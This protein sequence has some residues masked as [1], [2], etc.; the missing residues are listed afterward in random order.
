M[1]DTNE[2]AAG[3]HKGHEGLRL[4][5]FISGFSQTTKSFHGV[6]ALFRWAL[7]ARR[8]HGANGYR[9]ELRPWRDNWEAVA[10]YCQILKVEQVYLCAYS[11]G[12]GW[13]AMQLAKYLQRLGIEVGWLISCDGVYRW[14]VSKLARANPFNLRSIIHRGPLA[15]TIKIPSN[16]RNVYPL[17]QRGGKL[18]GHDFTCADPTLT[19]LHDTVWVDRPHGE[20]DDSEEFA[21]IVRRELLDLWT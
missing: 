10:R 7:F 17:R 11:W 9:I 13:G 16:V 1:S 5:L 19:T 4:V 8:A 21:E 6:F 20:M 12:V 15:P 18:R 2:H 14:G 3:G